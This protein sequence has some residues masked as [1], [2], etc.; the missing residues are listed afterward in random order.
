LCVAFFLKN[1]RCD[2]LALTPGSDNV[3]AWPTFSTALSVKALRAW[4]ASAQALH[5]GINPALINIIQFHPGIFSQFLLEQPPL[6]L[7]AFLVAEFFFLT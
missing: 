2:E 6:N 1:E 5:P 7:V 4:R 3:Y